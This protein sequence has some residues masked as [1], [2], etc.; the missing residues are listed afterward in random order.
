MYVLQSGS[1]YR[2]YRN[3]EWTGIY[4]TFMHVHRIWKAPVEYQ[5]DE[6]SQM[7]LPSRHQIQKLNPGE[8][9]NST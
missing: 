4:S 5:D 6:L 3:Y 7:T 9:G 2:S 8:H 1:T